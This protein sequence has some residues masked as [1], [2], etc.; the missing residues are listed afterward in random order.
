MSGP[1]RGINTDPTGKW[2]PGGARAHS[3]THQFLFELLL[4]FILISSGSRLSDRSF[5]IDGTR[6]FLDP[7]LLFV[8]KVEIV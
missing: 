8:L 5:V 4:D 6:L 1:R 2:A 7:R 3:R